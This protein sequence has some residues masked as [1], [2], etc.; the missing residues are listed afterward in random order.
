[1]IIFSFLYTFNKV[2]IFCVTIIAR[3]KAAL[4]IILSSIMYVKMVDENS[5]LELQV[6]DTM[7][8][9][10]RKENTTSI[11]FTMDNGPKTC[12][13]SPKHACA[14]SKQGVAI[15]MV[16]ALKGRSELNTRVSYFAWCS[17]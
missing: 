11:G 17:G 13:K 4:D 2:F 6:Q 12:V 9:E 16:L 5:E 1:M 10:C 14:T 15:V 7:L 3:K 8:I